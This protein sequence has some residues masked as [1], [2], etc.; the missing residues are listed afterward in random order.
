MGMLAP[1]TAS[2]LGSDAWVN[3]RDKNSLGWTWQDG[4]LEVLPGAGNLR[5]REHFG[6]CRLHIEFN[7]TADPGAEWKADGNS[8][9]YV[10]RRYEVQILNSYG[11]KASDESCGAIY[12]ARPPD[13]NASRPAGEWQTFDIVFRAPRWGG[14]EKV[15]NARMSVCHNGQL[16]HDDVAIA[17][18]TGSGKPEG[19]SEEPLRLQDHG[20]KCQFRNIWIERLELD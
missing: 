16:V 19:P 7:V 13:T 15:Q 12:T 1:G 5:T 9:V 20:S 8:G 14:G 18:K 3:E 2:L 4:L 10:Q 11:R 17:D 6:D